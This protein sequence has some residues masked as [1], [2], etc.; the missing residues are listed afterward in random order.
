MR[1]TNSRAS[2]LDD[3]G[4]PDAPP[5][6]LPWAKWFVGQAKLRRSDLNRDA[7]GLKAII[8]KLEKHAGWQA[9]GFDSMV[10]MCKTELAL[11]E[12]EVELIRQAKRG[13]TLGA[14]IAAAKRAK[15]LA[16]HGG[17][18]RSD[19]AEQGVHNT[20]VRGTTNA[21]Y[22]TARIARDRPDILERMKA[23]EFRSVR[24]AAI[25]AGIVKVPTPYEQTTKLMAKLTKPERKRLYEALAEEFGDA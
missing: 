10:G 1:T 25:E 4:D 19:D 24:A 9:L 13:V 3:V 12:N 6:S 15:P 8:A 7:T 21:D 22:L 14:V 17:D 5:G 23:G 20:L 2:V 18:R 11:D 16:E